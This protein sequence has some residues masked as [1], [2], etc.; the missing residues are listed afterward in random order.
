MGAKRPIGDDPW[1][2]NS[3][4]PFQGQGNG[5]STAMAPYGYQG[6]MGMPAA[7][8]QTPV[9]LGTF[10]YPNMGRGMGFGSMMGGIPMV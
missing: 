1:M 7:W 10:G 2:N 5:G 6:T 9:Q 4:R 8:P 3:K